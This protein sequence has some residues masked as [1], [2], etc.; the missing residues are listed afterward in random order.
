MELKATALRGA[1]WTLA[2]RLGLQLV[3]WPITIWVMRLLEPGDY[4]LFALALLVSGFITL[5]S[6]LGLGVALVQAPALSEAQTRMACT[7]V[8]LL[9]TGIAAI[10]IAL[11]PLMAAFFEEPDLTLVMWVLT[12]E[13]LISALAV[14]PLALLERGLNFKQVSLGH[15]TGGVAGSVVTLVAAFHDAGVWSLVAGALT[16]ASARSVM[17]IAFHGRLVIPGALRLETIRPMVMVSSHALTARFLWY[18]SGQ[19]DQLVLGRLLH[20]PVLGVYNV[21]AQLAMMPVS[22]AMEAVNRVV[23]PILS[24]MQSDTEGLRATHRNGTALLALYGFGACW[25]LAAVSPEFVTLVLGEKWLQAILPLAVLSLIAPLRM[26]C[27]FNNTVVTAVGMPQIATRE[28][29]L[30][31]VLIPLAVGMGAHVD[32]LRG[33]SLAWLAAYPMVYLYSMAR[34]AQAVKMPTGQVLRVV[35][36]PIVAGACMIG[37][38]WACRALLGENV[39]LGLRLAAGI[40][41]GGVTY[42]LVLWVIARPLLLNARGLALDLLRPQRNG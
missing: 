35:A 20:A 31:S 37:S 28:M 32:G 12:A 26:L 40:V 7:L 33:A 19:A 16:A 41:T 6:E 42:L 10:L 4:G 23:F 8:L 36:A 13:L 30:G 15:M 29:V 2:A 27:A 3:T 17:W 22:K 25:G 11:A 39:H 1:R 38:V 34:T 24:R 14:V 5:F 21:S 9:N 18:W